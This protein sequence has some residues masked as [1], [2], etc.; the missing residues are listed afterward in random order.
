M[1]SRN[2]LEKLYLRAPLPPPSLPTFIPPFLCSI[3]SSSWLT[4]LFLK[5]HPQQGTPGGC[6]SSLFCREMHKYHLIQLKGN[7]HG[8]GKGILCPRS[9][10]PRAAVGGM[11][12]TKKLGLQM[13]ESERH[14]YVRQLMES[15]TGKIFGQESTCIGNSSVTSESR[16]AQM[17]WQHQLIMQTN[18]WG[19]ECSVPTQTQHAALRGK[20][21]IY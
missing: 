2:P 21:I 18:K 13:K 4:H 9:V 5:Y 8:D 15:I 17:L 10:W 12:L 19:R 6:I 11:V 14:K 1:V 7:I 3:P 20:N 16:D